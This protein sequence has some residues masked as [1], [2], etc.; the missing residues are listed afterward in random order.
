VKICF[1]ILYYDAR[2]A[3]AD[4][5]AYV[6]R[7][8]LQRELPRELA[9]RGHQ[10]DVVYLYPHDLQYEH[11]GVTHHFVSP[12]RIGRVLGGAARAL[13]REAAMFEPAWRAAQRIRSLRPDVIHFHGMILTW[14]LVLLQL[15]LGPDAPPIVMHYHGG[16]PPQN[17]LARRAA[18]WGLRRTARQLF[19]TRDQADPFLAAGLLAGGAGVGEL[20]E[21]SSDM[22]PIPQAEARRQTDMHGDP[23][24]LWAGRLHPI[25]DPLTA[26]RG[27]EQ[28]ARALP[29]ARLYMHYLTGEMEPE[30]R[31]FVAERPDLAHRVLFRGR[32][33]FAQMRAIYSSADFLLQASLREF[34]GCAILEGMAC[35]AIPVVSDIP[36]FRAMTANGS[37]GVIFPV[38]DADALARGVLA[39]PPAALAERRAAVLA[40]FARHL[41]FPALAEQL[42]RL[43]AEL[44]DRAGSIA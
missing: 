25:K 12:G 39:I 11:A 34:S 21:T 20:V 40:H 1:V 4:P 27:F 26:L 44:R 38:G 43:Y 2:A 33:P 10:V 19:T 41:S 35:G 3:S 18:R 28:I 15:A 32:A 36:S 7:M 5:A 13:G 29:G 30:L 24:V 23:V 37:V 42:E 16:Y 17:S 31:A 9:A 22:R 6:D 8:V 14:N